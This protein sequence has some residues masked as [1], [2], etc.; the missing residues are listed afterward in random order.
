MSAR[1]PRRSSSSPS[2]VPPGAAEWLTPAAWRV[3]RQAEVVAG[4]RRQLDRFAPPGAEQVVVAADMDAVA[5]ALRAHVGRRVV[6]LASGDPGFFGI[7]VALRRLLPNA[8]ITTLPGVSSAQLAAARLGRPWHELRFASAHGLE[9]EGVIAAVREHAHV[10]ALTDARRTPQA[11][12]AALASAGVRARLTVLE[13]LGEPDESITTGAAARIA[14]QV[15][16][17]LSVVVVDREEAT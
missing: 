12:A 9:F 1:P 15:F 2:S 3:I 13:R 10:L 16:D 17:G 11:L 6:V 8:R 7:P 4:G 14:A 5:A